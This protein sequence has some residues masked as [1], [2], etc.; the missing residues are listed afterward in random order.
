MPRYNSKAQLWANHLDRFRPSVMTISEFCRNEQLAIPSFNYWRK[1]MA[2][3]SS[4]P[5]PPSTSPKS[6][7]LNEDLVHF[8]IKARGVRIVFRSSSVLAIDPVLTWASNQQSSAFQ[9][10]IV[11]D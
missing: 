2:E 10:L 5:V 9:Q 7:N 8:T 1:R 3:T 4:V 6:S 11:C